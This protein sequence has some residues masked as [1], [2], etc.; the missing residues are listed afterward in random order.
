MNIIN[1]SSP[2]E[3]T[4]FLE[5][6]ICYSNYRGVTDTGYELIPAIGRYSNYCKELEFSVLHEF[7]LYARAHFSKPPR[8]DWEWMYLAQ[9]YGLPTRILDWTLSPLTA[10]YFA[11]C[12][13][14]ETDFGV[15][16]IQR[17]LYSANPESIDPLTATRNYFLRPPHIDPR[18]ASQNSVFSIHSEPNLAW[19]HEELVQ[20]VFKGRRRCDVH[21]Q[22]RM[23]GIN[24]R[25]QFPDIHG[26]VKDIVHDIGGFCPPI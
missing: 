1:I 14:K 18:I 2:H 15:Y 6:S 13:N 4:D 17:G 19:R 7:R 9:H 25:T 24:H 11:S 12:G 10:L 26:V 23:L 5:K 21:E 3:V 22:L 8:T 16:A 20:F